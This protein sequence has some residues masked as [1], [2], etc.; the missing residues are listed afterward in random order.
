MDFLRK[1]KYIAA[2][3]SALF[4]DVWFDMCAYSAAHSA[5]A[6]GMFANFTYPLISM[7][8]IILVVEEQELK[9]KIKVALVEGAG[10]AVGTATFMTVRD[11]L[12]GAR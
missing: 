1:H 5:Y 9:G 11:Y 8:P 3:V 7:V 6:L 2:F 4:L 12:I 10:Y